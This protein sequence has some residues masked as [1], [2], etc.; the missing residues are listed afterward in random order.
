M[1]PMPKCTVFSS[2]VNPLPVRIT[3]DP[4]RPD[5]GETEESVIVPYEPEPAVT[6]NGKALLVWPPKFDTDTL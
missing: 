4:T 1:P 5:I 6:V 2:G 3:C